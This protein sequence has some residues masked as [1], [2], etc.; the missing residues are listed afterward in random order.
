MQDAPGPLTILTQLI[1]GISQLGAE[2]RAKEEARR[3][4]EC[5]LRELEARQKAWRKEVE[6]QKAR[7]SAGFAGEAEARAALSGK[8]GRPSPLDRRKFR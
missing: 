7:G 3:A 4:E 5:A 6:R 1:I 2:N 8:G